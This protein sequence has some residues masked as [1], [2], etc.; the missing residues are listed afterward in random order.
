MN[1]SL[2]TA[3]AT[4]IAALAAFSTTAAFAD[5][6]TPSYPQ[7][8]TVGKSVA[9]VRAELNA[10]RAAGQLIV[11]EASVGNLAAAGA[12][13]SRVQVKQALQQSIHLGELRAL[14]A[15]PQGFTIPAAASASRQ[16][17]ALR[18]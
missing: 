4:A 17:I 18:G 6:D 5:G 10:A 12:P 2:R 15:E 13:A 9:E 1:R 14:T 8:V 3:A 16:A 7:A 11:N